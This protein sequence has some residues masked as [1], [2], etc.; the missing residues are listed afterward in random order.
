MGKLICLLGEK[1]DRT[2][3]KAGQVFERILYCTDPVIP[4]I[5]HKDALQAAFPL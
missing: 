4:Y 5:P 2:R 3:A 1:I